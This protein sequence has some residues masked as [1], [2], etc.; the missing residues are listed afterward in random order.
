[1]EEVLARLFRLAA[2]LTLIQVEAF[3]T[4]F[5]RMAEVIAEPFS[6]APVRV[7][8]RA[9]VPAQ[10]LLSPPEPYYDENPHGLPGEALKLVRSRIVFVKRGSEFA[11]DSNETLVA[12][13]LQPGV[14][15]AW[16]IA[17][18]VQRM[19][20]PDLAPEVPAEWL[21]TLP[22]ACR[23]QNGRLRRFPPGDL[24]YVRVF[25]EVLR[26]SRR[27]SVHFEERQLRL[28]GEI[29]TKLDQRRAV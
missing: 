16:K 17:E 29:V 2:T 5:R 21:T 12:D 19:A 8:P 22:M 25:F 15:E 11:F 10:L 7:E 14:F 6:G 20:D 3:I 9:P 18:F 27:E 23:H 13:D 26:Y 4:T 24:K 28:L 1:M